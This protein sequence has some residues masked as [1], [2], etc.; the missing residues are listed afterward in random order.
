M[1]TDEL[2]ASAM[3]LWWVMYDKEEWGCFVVAETR[4]AAKAMF[5]SYWGDGEYIDIRAYK[6]KAVDR[7]EPAIYDM[8]CPELAALGEKYMS[9][10]E[11]E[12]LGR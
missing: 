10:E 3:Y 6:R 9:E 7:R 5:R 4:G 2:N 1:T 12:A 11:M 8:D